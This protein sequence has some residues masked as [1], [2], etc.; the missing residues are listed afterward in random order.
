[1]WVEQR[2]VKRTD[3]KEE[4]APLRDVRTNDTTQHVCNPPHVRYGI[5]YEIAA[6]RPGFAMKIPIFTGLTNSLLKY[7]RRY[8]GVWIIVRW[9]WRLLLKLQSPVC[10]I[11]KLLLT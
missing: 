5:H 9:S 7:I 10:S 6:C 2:I 4:D 11:M 3:S 8:V 1:M